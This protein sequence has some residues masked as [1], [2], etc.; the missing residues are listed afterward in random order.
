MIN[1]PADIVKPGA[2]NEVTVETG[3]NLYQ[4]KYID[5]DD[6]EFMNLILEFR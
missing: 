3:K 6:M 5:Y 1:I 2:Y 4:T